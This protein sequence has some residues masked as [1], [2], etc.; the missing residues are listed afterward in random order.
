MVVQVYNNWIG[1]YFHCNE[2]KQVKG[3][4]AIVWLEAANAEHVNSLCE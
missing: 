2:D 4:I 1:Q 3:S